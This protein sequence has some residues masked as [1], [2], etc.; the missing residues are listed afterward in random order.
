[1][2]NRSWWGMAG[3][4]NG[5]GRGSCHSWIFLKFNSLPHLKDILVVFID[6]VLNICVFLH[7]APNRAHF[8]SLPYFLSFMKANSECCHTW[9]QNSYQLWSIAGEV[10]PTLL[11]QIRSEDSGIDWKCKYVRPW[12]HLACLALSGVDFLLMDG[13]F[14][15]SQH[16]LIQQLQ[17]V[18]WSP[19]PRFGHH[20]SLASQSPVNVCHCVHLSLCTPIPMQICPLH[21]CREAS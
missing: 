18:C 10:G 3:M 5:G 1:M 8:S 6:L 11:T 19:N 15:H 4:G 7:P 20:K 9:S 13:Q 14:W 16:K 12:W 17:Q 21:F 2:N